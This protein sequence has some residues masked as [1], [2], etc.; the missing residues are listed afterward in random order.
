[1]IGGQHHGFPTAMPKG[2]KYNLP[3]QNSS[4]KVPPPPANKA[5]R[6]TAIY[7]LFSKDAVH[8]RTNIDPSSGRSVWIPSFTAFHCAFL[9]QHHVATSMG[10]VEWCSGCLGL[11]PHQNW[12]QQRPAFAGAVF[13]NAR[14]STTSVDVAFG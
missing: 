8:S 3:P 9:Q 13:R 4:L 6:K 7:F 11:V 10:T 12:R 14:L 5:K 2:C 1:L